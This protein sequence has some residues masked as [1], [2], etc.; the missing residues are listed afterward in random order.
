MNRSLAVA[1]GLLVLGGAISA[2]TAP[3][4]AQAGPPQCAA[5]TTLSAEAKKKA[6]AVQAAIKAKVDRGEICTLMTSFVASEGKVIK[7]LEDNKMWCG[8]PDDAIK[9]SKMNHEK[10]L[11]FREV[12]CSSAGGPAPKPPTLSDAIKMP[13]VDSATN[14]KTGRGT[15]DTLT[16]NPLSR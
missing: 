13:S 5:F 4:V 16:G 7:F 12:A 8:V 10:S 11:K 2:G 15:F 14:T 6:D 1:C 9:M 3:A